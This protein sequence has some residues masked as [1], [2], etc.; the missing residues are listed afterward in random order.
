MG[1]RITLLSIRF[2][3]MNSSPFRYNQELHRAACQG[4]RLAGVFASCSP[5]SPNLR[6]R[7]W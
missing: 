2:M 4:Y 6:C 3:P 1:I 5:V 7:P